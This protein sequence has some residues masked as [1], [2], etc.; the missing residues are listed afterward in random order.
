M[1]RRLRLCSNRGGYEA[2]PDPPRP[3]ELPRVKAVLEGLGIPVTDARVMLI[4]T[5]ESEVTLSRAGRI[6]FKTQ[7]ARL[8][9]REFEQL[10]ALLG[11][12]EMEDSHAIRA[13]SG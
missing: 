2:L 13:E 5:L 7:D 3:L 1:Y 12:P 4:V 6:L 9:E 8:A 10:R 11:L